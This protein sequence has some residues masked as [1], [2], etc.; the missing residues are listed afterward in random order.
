MNKE[1][2]NNLV[3]EYKEGNITSEYGYSTFKMCSN[4]KDILKKVKTILGNYGSSNKEKSEKEDE[5][6][7]YLCYLSVDNK[8]YLYKKVKPNEPGDL[9]FEENGKNHLIELLTCFGNDAS[10]HYFQ[11]RMHELFNRTIKTNSKL[12]KKK[13]GYHIKDGIK[14]FFKDYRK[15]CNKDYVKNKTYDYVELLIVTAEYESCIPNWMIR[16]ISKESFKN[17]PFD[18][19]MIIDFFSSGK[20]GNPTIIKDYI[21]ELERQDNIYIDDFTKTI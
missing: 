15:K 9:I 11:K 20:D 19:I 6:F 21:R 8:L 16:Y 2:Y 14:Q 17:N 10:Y 18:K 7:Y 4:E 1:K 3:L 5:L 13:Y 12:D